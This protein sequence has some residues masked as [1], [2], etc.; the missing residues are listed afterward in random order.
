MIR[1][2]LYKREKRLMSTHEARLEQ[3]RSV[4]RSINRPPAPPPMADLKFVVTATREMEQ[5]DK[6]A[7]WI[8]CFLGFSLTGAALYYAFFK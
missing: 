3:C 1:W 6:V 8:L 7:R 4:H 5:A 2:D